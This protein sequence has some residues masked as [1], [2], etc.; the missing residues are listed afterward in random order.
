MYFRR[1]TSAGRAYLQIVESHRDGDQ[2]RQQVIATL[3]RFEEL[4]ASGQ[5]ER[6]VRSG[7]RFAAKAMVLSAASD[8]TAIK[9]AVRRIGP[10]LV[11]ERLWEETGCRAVITE[12]AGKRKHGFALERAMF[13]TVLHRLFVSG[14]DRAA[15]RWREDYAIVGIE[16][17][18]LLAGRGAA[19][20]RAGRPHA[21]RA[22]L[23][24][25]RGGGAAVRVSARPAHA[26]RP[27]VH[28]HHQPLLRGRRRPDAGPARL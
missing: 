12:L 11:F 15:D 19:R 28:G 7:A 1:K 9:I 24:E 13:L 14:S 25:G 10:A 3:G 5:L 8:D 18:D 2:V 22:A 16:G 20:E 23:S 21:I 27:S 4:Q 26:A 6:L 17:L